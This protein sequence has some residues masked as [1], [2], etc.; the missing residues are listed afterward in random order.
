MSPANKIVRHG[1]EAEKRNQQKSF[2]LA[3]RFRNAIGPKE[4]KG[5]GDKLGRMIFGG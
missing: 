2:D 3:G 4:A 1:I 5:L